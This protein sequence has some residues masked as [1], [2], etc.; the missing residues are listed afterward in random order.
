MRIR[1]LLATAGLSTAL[2]LS[3]TVFPAVASS[4]T[5]APTA[6]CTSDSVF[7]DGA[8]AYYQKCYD[9][10]R[11]RVRGWVEDTDADGACAY[12]SV[13]MDNGYFY[14]WKACP[15]GTRTQVDTGYQSAFSAFVRLSVE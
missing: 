1:R 13:N 2:A 12:F 11:A 3:T 8:K 6:D 7:L 10:G 14:T 15:K 5:A 4:A 9:G